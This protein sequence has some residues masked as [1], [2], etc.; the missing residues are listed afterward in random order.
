MRDGLHLEVRYRCCALKWIGLVHG[1]TKK[2]FGNSKIKYL[3]YLLLFRRIGRIVN[4]IING[5][6]AFTLSDASIDELEF[7]E[8]W[9]YGH[10]TRWPYNKV[11]TFAVHA[12]W[13][14]VFGFGAFLSEMLVCVFNK[15]EY[16]PTVPTIMVEK[17]NIK[18]ES[19][20]CITRLWQTYWRKR[21]FEIVAYWWV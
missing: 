13:Q 19:W 7:V 18:S 14:L 17:R 1:I 5:S 2:C 20:T 11:A 12:F 3:D 4:N 16:V 8:F 21:F 9:M 15:P 10:L 6:L